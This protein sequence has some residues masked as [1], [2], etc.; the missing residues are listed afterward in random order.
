MTAYQ[1]HRLVDGNIPVSYNRTE[2]AI[3][4]F[5]NGRKNWLFA[6]SVKGVETN[7]MFYSVI[8]TACANGLEQEEY[9]MR[10]FSASPA[11]FVFSVHFS[12]SQPNPHGFLANRAI[13]ACKVGSFAKIYISWDLEIPMVIP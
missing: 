13:S 10:M 1:C 3:R 2:N 9:L 8:A 11:F 6:A 12:S 5:T 4:P 7:A